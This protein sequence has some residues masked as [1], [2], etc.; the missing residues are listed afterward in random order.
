MKKRVLS[1][2]MS[3]ILLVNLLPATARAAENITV[4]ATVSDRGSIACENGALVA[5]VP[6]TVETDDGT[7]TVDAV[8]A[9]L[10]EMYGKGYT[11]GSYVTKLWGVSTGNCLFFVNDQALQVDVTTDVVHDGDRLTASLNQDDTYYSDWY[12]CFDRSR[13]T[14]GVGDDVTLTL[15][16]YQGM[17]DGAAVPVSGVSV[18]AMNVSGTSVSG[19]AVTDSAGTA[20]IRFDVPGTYYVTANGTVRDTVTA[21]SM[22]NLGGDPAVYGTMDYTT[23]DFSVAY[24]DADYG[25]GPYPADEV[26]YVDFDDWFDDQDSYYALHTNQLLVDCPTIAPVCVVTVGTAEERADWLLVQ[27]AKD[28]LTWDQFNAEPQDAVTTAFTLPST[29]T[30]GNK[31]VSVYWT[32]SDTSVLSVNS[33]NGQI[34]TWIE[35][36]AAQDADV[37][38]TASLVYET[39]HDTK[40]FPLAIKAEGVNDAKESVVGFK[41]LMDGI[42]AAQMSSTDPWM[43]LDMAGYGQ[44]VKAGD[45]GWS[46]TVAKTLAQAATGGDTSALIDEL[47]TFKVNGAYAIYTTPYVLLAYD[48][49]GAVED[50]SFTCTRAAMKAAMIA[51]L[52]DLDGNYAGVD[53]MAPLLAALA[54][55][56]EKGDAALD[57]AVRTGIAWLSAQ[58]ND[59]GTYSYFGTKN[60]N[61]TAMVVVSLAALGIDAHRDSRFIKD[62]HSAVEGL[63]SFALSDK[64]GFGYKGNVTE[65]ALATEQ[66][67]RALVSYARFA[68]SGGEPYNIY[69]QAK[70]G[71]DAPADPKITTTVKPQPVTPTDKSISASVRVS[72]DTG[73]WLS[74][75][76]SVRSGVSVYDVLTSV[77]ADNGYSW[78]GSSNYISYITNPDGVRL[79]EFSTGDNSGWLYKVNGVLPSEPLG[80]YILESNASIVFYYTNDW[81]KDPDA[82]KWSSNQTTDSKAADKVDALIDAIGTVTPER[83]DAIRAARAAYDALSAEQK[84]LVENYDALLAAEK[85]L[86]ALQSGSLPFTDIK[87]GAWYADAVKYAYEKGLMNG[88]SAAAF[89]PDGTATRS[90]IVTILYRLAG[91]SAVSGGSFADVNAGEWYADAVEWA[92]ANGIVSG[93]DNGSFGPD[94]EITREQLAVILYRYA[95]RQ[96]QGFTGLW[97]FPLSFSDAA[98]VSS[99]ADEAMHWCVMK[100]IL[101]G[102]D[103]SMLEPGATATRAQIAAILQRFCELPQEDSKSEAERAFDGAASYLT[104]AVPAPR[105]GSIG[106]EWT[107]IALSRAGAAVKED[108]FTVYEAALEQTVRESAGVLSER[109]YTEYSRAILA[110]SALGKDA[111][112]IAGYDLTLALG[113]YEKTTAQGVNGAIYALLALDSREYPVPQNADAKTQATRQM[114]IDAI[115]AAQLSD[116]SWS[117]TGESADPDLTAMA[118]QAL[119]KYQEQSAV[120]AA[121]NRALVCLSTMQ[122]ADGGFSSW[123]TE[124]AESC[125]QVILALA[126]LGISVD[127]TRFVKDGGSVLDA[128]LSYQNADGGFCHTHGGE[129]NLMAS[130]QAACALASLVRAENGETGFYRMA[131]LAERAAA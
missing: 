51:F 95:K 64:T 34:S 93:Y 40:V 85:A 42:A 111:R 13:V 94:D 90:Q 86:A 124:N 98:A 53:D 125:A 88:V 89:A 100:G 41:P 120:K 29:A 117:F 113:D 128:L 11:G 5:D 10:H 76:V 20:T 15:K 62:G 116:G 126:E 78:E 77:L 50:E 49:A 74:T 21:W 7:A 56:Y 8:L 119:A 121:V 28:A 4:Y 54:P 31:L 96:G 72:G 105:Y 65:N 48:A 23:S 107:V 38:L 26:K 27:S 87:S 3:F 75:R 18:S 57:A 25:N 30:V 6:V 84:K 103:Q 68:E 99:W 47:K 109:K 127:D 102:T 14:V 97:Y 52:N 24:T 101:S 114:Y 22:M 91:S 45:Y 80:E 92:S 73:V 2:L 81:T 118:L 60:A 79:G 17:G 122:N 16:G 131:A 36:P 1:L 59:D 82:G 9:K 70:A 61:S 110:L 67:L 129:T 46:S 130:E 43:V 12:T 33:Y 115:L 112:D 108:Y 19:E 71:E 37:R 32:S 44:D 83:A 35:R 63:M 104:A 123:S 55:Y 106:G 69:L 39:A 66:G 58:Q